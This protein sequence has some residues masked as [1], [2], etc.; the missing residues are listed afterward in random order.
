VL[1]AR[2]V[3]DEGSPFYDVTVKGRGKPYSM[4][5]D[6]SSGAVLS[7]ANTQTAPALVA[8]A[9]DAAPAQVTFLDA[10]VQPDKPQIKLYVGMGTGQMAGMNNVI[11]RPKY[12]VGAKLAP[13]LKGMPEL[14]TEV[15][16]MLIYGVAQTG[17]GSFSTT[18][19]QEWRGKLNSVYNFYNHNDVAKA[20]VG[21]YS[22]FAV[23]FH[24]YDRYAQSAPATIYA[25][26]EGEQLK[27][28]FLHGLDLKLSISDDRLDSSLHNVIFFSGSRIGPNLLTYKPLLGLMWHNNIMLMGNNLDPKLSLFTDVWVYFARKNN[29]PVFNM[30]DGLGGTKREIYLSYGLNYTWSKNTDIRLLSYGFNN[31]NRG[32][33]NQIPSGFR[34]GFA[35]TL[36][37]AY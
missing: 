17:S 30:H 28:Q 18:Q 15:D 3:S 11:I 19:F 27:R 33:S 6:A 20:G 4:R 16:T 36:E 24:S 22:E 23:P 21:W 13:R 12:V 32:D 1:S 29:T 26:E 14:D 9:P 34:D 25:Q 35:I 10:Q 37:R 31:L 7:S 5:V 8:A 2:L